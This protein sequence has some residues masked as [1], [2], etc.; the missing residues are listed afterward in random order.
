MT[1]KTKHIFLAHRSQ[2]N[3]TEY[4]A[5]ETAKEMLIEGDA[6]LSDDA[7][8]IDTEPAKPTKLIQI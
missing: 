4:L 8:I 2:H 1:S 7:K 6:D 3:N 5:H